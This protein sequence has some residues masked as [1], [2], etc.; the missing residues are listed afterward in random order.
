MY[1]FGSNGKPAGAGAPPG[2]NG[3]S[4]AEQQQQSWYGKPGAFNY[5][6]AN[7]KTNGT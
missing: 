4:N 1:G 2:S 5:N 7:G 3:G 6:A